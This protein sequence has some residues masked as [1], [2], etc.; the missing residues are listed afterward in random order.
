MLEPLEQGSSG[1]VMLKILEFSF[2]LELHYLALKY[3][4]AQ[5]SLIVHTV[6]VK[7]FLSVKQEEGS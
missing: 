6:A 4:S 5:I 1:E 2:I 7:Q 3:Y